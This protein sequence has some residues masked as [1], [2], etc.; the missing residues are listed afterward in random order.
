MP[1]IGTDGETF[2]SHAPRPQ[3]ARTAS[4]GVRFVDGQAPGLV[5][6]AREQDLPGR[7]LVEVSPRIV[8]E[9]FLLKFG[10][11]LPTPVKGT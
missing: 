10:R 3:L 7:A 6:H 1:F 2:S 8:D 5:V 11:A 9:L 4:P